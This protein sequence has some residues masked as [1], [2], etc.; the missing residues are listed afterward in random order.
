L[1]DLQVYYDQDVAMSLNIK[2]T[3]MKTSSVPSER[4]LMYLISLLFLIAGIYGL[5][6]YNGSRENMGSVEGILILLISLRI[7][8]GDTPFGKFRRSILLSIFGSIGIIVGIFDLLLPY[9]LK[10]LIRIL[11]IGI[12]IVYSVMCFIWAIKGRNNNSMTLRILCGIFG[13]LM[14]LTILLMIDLFGSDEYLI[15]GIVMLA[16][17][18]TMALMAYLRIDF[19]IHEGNEFPVASLTMLFSGIVMLCEVIAILLMIK[20]GDEMS[21]RGTMAVFLMILALRL[22]SAGDTPIGKTKRTPLVIIVGMICM[23]IAMVTVII[24]SHTLYLLMAY[25]LGLLNLTEGLRLIRMLLKKDEHM[26][27]VKLRI[28]ISSLTMILFGINALMPGIFSGTMMLITMTLM[29]I[30]MISL[31]TTVSS[32]KLKE[33][34]AANRNYA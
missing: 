28:W 13:I 6:Q 26:E 15:A 25:A 12:L 22:I 30:T 18:I 24:P 1:K 14:I 7:M 11:T 31:G 5:Y 23:T 9:T 27:K 10:D 34:K 29:S 17:G 4:I 20:E 3:M 16:M 21:M 19:P 33:I 8:S 32:L 2:R